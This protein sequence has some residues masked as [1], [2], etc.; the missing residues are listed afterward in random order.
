MSNA[1]QIS[2]CGRNCCKAIDHWL[3]FHVLMSKLSHPSINANNLCFILLI[4]GILH[5]W[6]VSIR[7]LSLLQIKC[8][9]LEEKRTV[10]ESWWVDQVPIFEQTFFITVWKINLSLVLMITAPL[11]GIPFQFCL[12]YCLLI[13]QGRWCHWIWFVW[14]RSQWKVSLA[15]ITR[16]SIDRWQQSYISHQNAYFLTSTIIIHTTTIELSA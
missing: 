14:R 12:V 10:V 7:N 8:R 5:V 11:F 15:V 4:S 3:V 16:F 2:G 9:F 6:L 1:N 13:V